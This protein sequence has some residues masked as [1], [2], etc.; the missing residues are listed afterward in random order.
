MTNTW[1]KFLG[2]PAALLS[3]GLWVLAFYP[4]Q[5]AAL[6]WI[7]FVPLLWAL[8]A[9]IVTFWQLWTAGTLAWVAQLWWL[10]YVTWVGMLLLCVYLGFYLV[11]WGRWMS[12]VF[13]LFGQRNSSGN[14]AAALLG[15]IGWA[16]LEELRGWFLTGFPWNGLGVSQYKNAA[17]IQLAAVGGVELLSALMIFIQVIIATTILRLISEVRQR[18][19]MLAHWEFTGGLAVL[20]VAFLFGVISIAQTPSGQ[21]Q[22]TQMRV[23]LVQGNVP[24]DVKFS[25]MSLEETVA[26]YIDPTEVLAASEPDLVIWPETA[27]GYGIF[28]HSFIA[29]EVTRLLEQTGLTL[30]AGSV[31]VEAD[32]RLFNAAFLLTPGFDYHAVRASAYRKQHLVVFGEFVPGRDWLP[33]LAEWIDMPVDYHPGPPNAGIIPLPAAGQ[34]IPA[35]M[36][37]CFEDLMPR[38]ARNRAL[39]GARVFVNL[40]NDG[41]FRDSPAAMAHAA[42][43]VFRCVENRLPMIRATNTGVTCVISPQGAFTNILRDESGRHTAMAGAMIANVSIPPRPTYLTFYQRIGHLFGELAAVVMA[44]VLLYALRR[45]FSKIAS[46]LQDVFRENIHPKSK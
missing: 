8:H 3:A 5:E 6:A 27:T 31:D 18:R 33:W 11:L 35:G 1:L 36:L 44:A 34:T 9:R 15:A 26:A 12:L 32:G 38:L 22:L 46:R 13:A 17:L 25:P 2:L 43:A 28:Q 16:A 45:R 39:A 29:S 7:C 20:A 4:H 41:W 14:L 42:H 23:G 37:I 10:S 21:Q 24:Q 40:T 19:R 30:L